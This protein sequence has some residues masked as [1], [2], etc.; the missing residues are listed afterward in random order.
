MA[1]WGKVKEGWDQCTNHL[2]QQSTSALTHSQQQFLSWE[3]L[4]SDEWKSSYDIPKSIR[5]GDYTYDLAQMENGVSTEKQLQTES[6]KYLFPATVPF[7]DTPS[8]L[9][10]ASEKGREQAVKTLQVAMLRMLTLL[11]AGK[12]RFTLFD[13]VGLGEN[14]SC[15]YASGRLRR[16][17]DLKSYL[18]RVITV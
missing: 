11:P 5:L 12:V 13:P 2:Q 14:F 18:D 17:D 7:P 16:V 15:L 3:Q 6:T 9:L 10:K 8:L 1:H 4:A